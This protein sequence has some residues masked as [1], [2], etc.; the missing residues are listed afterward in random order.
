MNTLALDSMTS[1]TDI[2]HH[3]SVLMELFPS[4]PS[5]I[6]SMLEARFDS[7]FEAASRCRDGD[8][9]SSTF[10]ARGLNLRHFLLDF[11]YPMSLFWDG[12]V[13]VPRDSV[14][15]VLYHLRAYA[16]LH[17]SDLNTLVS[18][19][20]AFI[21]TKTLLFAHAPSRKPHPAPAIRMSSFGMNFTA[22]ASYIRGPSFSTKS[23]FHESEYTR[24]LP[25]T[26]AHHSSSASTRSLH[27]DSV[28]TPSRTEQAMSRPL[29]SLMTTT[30]SASPSSPLASAAYNAAHSSHSTC[31]PSLKKRLFED[32]VAL[33]RRTKK[34]QRQSGQP[35]AESSKA[36]SSHPRRHAARGVRKH[37]EET[38]LFIR[39]KG[40]QEVLE[41]A[42]DD[43][44][45]QTSPI[46]KVIP[47]SFLSRGER[48]EGGWRK[49][50]VKEK[51]NGS[52]E[53]GS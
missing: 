31:S 44:P 15:L 40:D 50:I 11:R 33:A 21:S 27:A 8:T 19:T 10:H 38:V 29:R 36:G 45:P 41:D 42:L 43:V 51:E 48:L 34:S 22:T 1:E 46:T 20:C 23:H 37:K 24:I 30:S 6:L 35:I 14:F 13:V 16:T 7:L 53:K 26:G 47:G 5:H 32:E 39:E 28:V 3:I 52:S 18:D 12:K 2:A 49:R 4:T 17:E 25:S 9:S